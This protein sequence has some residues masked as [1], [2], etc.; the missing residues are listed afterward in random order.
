MILSDKDINAILPELNI[1]TNGEATEFSQEDQV[2]PCSIDF[3]LSSVFWIPKKRWKIDLRRS[4][5]LEIQPRRYYKKIILK[6]GEF[7]T[8]RP[9][10]FLI[11][12]IHEKFIIPEGYAGDITGRSSFSRLGL[13]VHCTGNFINPGWSGHMPLQ[14]INQSRNSIKIYPHLPICQL[15]LFQLSSTSERTYGVKELQSKYMD[16][17]GGPSYWW[18]DKRI[19]ELQKK[20]GEVDISLAIQNEIFKIIGDQEPEVIERM[21]KCIDKAKPDNLEN[22]HSLLEFFSKKE[23]RRRFIRIIALNASK[24]AFPLFSTIALSLWFTNDEI[25]INIIVTIL[26]IVLLPLTLYAFYTEVG[27]HLGTKELQTLERNRKES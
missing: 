24:S 16:D 2:Q 4:K 6:Q 3:R 13:M 11:G 5:L 8:L 15:R 14:L 19:K 21:E 17:D 23:D 9:G 10:H 27:D 18:R 22:A 25:T 7:I 26:A 12:R 1:Q 20:L